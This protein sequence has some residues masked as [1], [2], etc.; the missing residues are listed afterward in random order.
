MPPVGSLGTG[1][2]RVNSSRIYAVYGGYRDSRPTGALGRYQSRYLHRPAGAEHGGEA[3]S[4]L[5][6][7]WRRSSSPVVAGGDVAVG[8]QPRSDTSGQWA[9]DNSYRFGMVVVALA[10]LVTSPCVSMWQRDAHNSRSRNFRY[11]IQL[12]LSAKWHFYTEWRRR[13]SPLNPLPSAICL[14]AE[15]LYQRLAPRERRGNLAVSRG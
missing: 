9:G 11:A 5:N 15:I 1:R 8:H 14:F 13:T 4:Q 2:H 3:A 10:R 7:H 12:S 6:L